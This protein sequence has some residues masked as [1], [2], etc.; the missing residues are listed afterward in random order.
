MKNDEKE[1]NKEGMRKEHCKGQT[2]IKNIN[3]WKHKRNEQREE[4]GKSRVCVLVF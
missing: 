3:N 4:G 2:K 1:R